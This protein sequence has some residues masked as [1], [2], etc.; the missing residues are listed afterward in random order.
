MTR[1]AKQER[2]RAAIKLL[3]AVL[4]FFWSCYVLLVR[5]ES[6]SLFRRAPVAVVGERERERE[7]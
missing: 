5:V 4:T 7:K 3:T 6:Y 1:E 2:E